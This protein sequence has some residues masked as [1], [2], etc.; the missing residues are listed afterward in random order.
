MTRATASI[1]A[2][3]LFGL[4]SFAH[5]QDARQTIVVSTPWLRAT[6]K[7]APVAGGY[8]TVTNKGSASDRLLSASL[9]IASKGEVHS[10]TMANG[11][12]HMERLDKGLEIKPGATVTLTPGGYHV[13]FIKPTAQLKQGENIKGVLNFEKAGMVAVTFA[14]AGMA[15]KSAPGTKPARD[16]SNM[17]GMDM[18]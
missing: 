12:M 2:F 8:V 7:G 1:L 4:A 10:M 17:P 9:S 14:V 6:P 13:M 11:V 5:A 16:M 18:H 3:A 15:A